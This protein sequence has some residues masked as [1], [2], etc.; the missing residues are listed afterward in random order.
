MLYFYT[1]KFFILGPHTAINKV[2]SQLCTQRY[3][4]L[5]LKE[6]CVVPRTEPKLDPY[7][8]SADM[9]LVLGVI[10]NPSG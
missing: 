5:G 10:F 7:K 4:L 9:F 6:P 1:F 3:L 8:A 2:F